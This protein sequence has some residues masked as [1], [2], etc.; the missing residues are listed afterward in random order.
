MQP[1]IQLIV[2][3]MAGTTV[4]DR[5]EVLDCFEQ[6][7]RADGIQAGRTRLNAL[8]G[9]SKLEVFQL[10]WREQLGAVAVDEVI[11]E[12]AEQSFQR[13]RT[14]LEA[15]YQ[16][17]PVEAVAGAEE[18]FAW[19]RAQG[20]RVALNTGFYRV[21]T[22]I[23]LQRLG[24]DK[25]LDDQYVGGTGSVIDLSLT[26]DEWPQGRPAPYMIQHA[27]QVFG[28]TDPLRVIKIG[29]TPVDLQ[30]G[31][32]AGCRLSL[33][34]T[35]GSHTREELA[36]CDNDGL[37]DDLRE[38]RDVVVHLTVNGHDFACPAK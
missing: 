36:K 9:V 32:R 27:M 20:I 19:C 28:I 30:E 14:M 8:M 10:L 35:N 18:L 21:V 7:C 6:A 12:K 33:A 3:D 38:L 5:H 34:V 22:M 24:W 4:R 37:L 23:I 15:H 16:T 29:D 31:R 13:F 25:G 1:T 17:A 11:R 26:S 2:F